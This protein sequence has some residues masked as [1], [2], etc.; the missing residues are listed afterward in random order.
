MRLLGYLLTWQTFKQD[1]FPS[2]HVVCTG[3][4]GERIEGIIREK[5]TFPERRRPDGSMVYPGFS[6]YTVQVKGEGLHGQQQEDFFETKDV[7]RDRRNFSKHLIRSFLKN[8]LTKEAWHGAP[9][10]VKESLALECDLPL[11]IPPHL[12]QSARI[13][14]KKAAKKAHMEQQRQAEQSMFT[15]TDFRQHP[16]GR[17]G[18]PVSGL[19]GPPIMHQPWQSKPLGGKQKTKFIQHNFDLMPQPGH[20]NIDWRHFPVQYPPHKGN[21]EVQGFVIYP[22][23]GPYGQQGGA[24]QQVTTLPTH[25][26]DKA[27]SPPEIPQIKYPIEDI[28]VPP[29]ET[30]TH[31][32]TFKSFTDT[33]VAGFDVEN[34]FAGGKYDEKSVGSLLEVWNTL[35]VHNEV[36][37]LDSFTFDDLAEALR[38]T[39]TDVECELLTEVHCAVLKQ[40]VNDKGDLMIDLPRIESTSGDEEMEEES[41]EKQDDDDDEEPS[42]EP[43]P[44]RRTTR[45]SLA[46]AEALAMAS[47]RD[48][49]PENIT[50]H[51]AAELQSQNPW[52]ERCK[53]RAF[54]DSHWQPILACL[55]YQVSLNDWM[56]E[57]CEK[58]LAQLLPPDMEPSDDTVIEQY[59]RL[60]VNLRL[61]ALEIITMLSIRTKA[62]REHLERMSQEM[63]DLR[64]KKIEQQRLK[65]DL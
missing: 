41:S 29:K 64:K 19:S 58:I 31:R 57:R 22:Q 23:D 30:D 11:Q 7:T 8:A 1:Y 39:S 25:R 10:V 35:N 56:K 13:A 9:W 6:K 2:E 49:T 4:D 3:Q 16:Q 12:Q 40:L 37:V 38:F 43:E 26:K 44:L 51:R 24:F 32:P 52:R 60:N 42:P 27:M 45:G 17:K 61:D 34:D 50:T 47:A 55:I 53:E 5:V 62:L 33:A 15:I 36:F 21:G 48:A 63:T 28:D 20:H 14:E 54:R 59:S 46:K 18:P 65:K